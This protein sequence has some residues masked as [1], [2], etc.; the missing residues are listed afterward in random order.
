MK[1]QK[2]TLILTLLGIVT[3]IFLAQS[4]PIGTATISKIQTSQYKTTIQLQN[5][6]VELIIFDNLNLKLTKGDK[7]NFQGKPSTYKNQE[8]IIISK[9][10]K[11]K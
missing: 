7:I 2:L 3:L 5:H 4:K 11:V 9:I 10:S 1:L 6:D 8:Q